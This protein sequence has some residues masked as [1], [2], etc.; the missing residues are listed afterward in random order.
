MVPSGKYKKPG[1]GAARLSK[2]KKKTGSEKRSPGKV[3]GLPAR[4]ASAVGEV[5]AGKVADSKL[6]EIIEKRGLPDVPESRPHSSVN[7]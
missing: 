1:K 7:S 2:R 5:A 6:S 4:R 3:T